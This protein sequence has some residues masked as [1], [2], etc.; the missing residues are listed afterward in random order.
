MSK[1]SSITKAAEGLAHDVHDSKKARINRLKKM[2]KASKKKSGENAIDSKK[3]KQIKATFL[4][5]YYDRKNELYSTVEVFE[6]TVY[7]IEGIRVIVRAP[8]NAKILAYPYKKR[9]GAD[10]T[11]SYFLSKRLGKSTEGRYEFYLPYLYTQNTTLADLRKEEARRPKQLDIEFKAI[12]ID[13]K[14]IDKLADKLYKQFVEN[15]G[16]PK[17]LIEPDTA[18]AQEI[19]NYISEVSKVTLLPR[20]YIEKKIKDAGGNDK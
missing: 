11:V 16:L 6:D 15:C 14:E 18:R 8:K 10:N 1:K 17:E 9:C 13:N 7:A 20:E 4:S 19:E 3:E 2:E 5:S 12:K